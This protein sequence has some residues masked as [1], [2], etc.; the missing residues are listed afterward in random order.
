MNL[1]GGTV[2]EGTMASGTVRAGARVGGTVREGTRASGNMGVHDAR[3]D[4][5]ASLKPTWLG[6]KPSRS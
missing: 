2:R 6:V 4:Q 5:S 3:N 1:V